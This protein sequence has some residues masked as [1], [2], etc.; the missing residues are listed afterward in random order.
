[1]PQERRIYNIL[2]R[3][4]KAALHGCTVDKQT[5]FSCIAKHE[6]TPGR[7]SRRDWEAWSR[8]QHSRTSHLLLPFEPGASVL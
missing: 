2:C 3:F 4:I 6:S 1:M 8:A 5:A 7:E